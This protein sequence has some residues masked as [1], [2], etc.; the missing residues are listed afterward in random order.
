MSDLKGRY[1]IL[2]AGK[3]WHQGVIG[4]VASRL[5]RDYNRPAIVL[6]ITDD[7]AH[8][9][10][11]SIGNLNLVEILT[12]SSDILKR[13]GGHPMAVGLGLDE[14]NIEKFRDEFEINVRKQLNNEDLIDKLDYDG[15][16]EIR[17]LCDDFFEMLEHLS[18]FGHSNPTPVFRFRGLTPVKLS[19][20]GQR[21]SRGLLRDHRGDAIGF[22][23]F[24][25]GPKDMPSGEWDVIAT[26]QLNNHFGDPRP[27]LQIIDIKPMF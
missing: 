14:S 18:P 5:A 3:D 12:R 23:A 15:E 6:T 7:E 20:A 27:Q 26:P 10:G 19:S 16:I 1:S 25:R 4:I 21:H 13:F 11:R 24:N 17:D 9:S 2:A 8:G 22:I